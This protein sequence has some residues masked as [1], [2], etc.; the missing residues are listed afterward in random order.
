ME[1]VRVSTKDSKLQKIVSRLHQRRSSR[2][3]VSKSTKSKILTPAYEVR[4]DTRLLKVGTSSVEIIR[5]EHGSGWVPVRRVCEIL[6][7]APNSQ[8]SKL[9][10]SA[11]ATLEMIYSSSRD[12]KS[13]EHFCISIESVSVWVSTIDQG[14]IKGHKT[15]AY[16]IRSCR[17]GL[18]K[19]GTSSDPM[20]RLRSIAG[21][22]PDRFELLA[23][24]GDES[25]LHKCL[26]KSKVHGEWFSPCSGILKEIR[27]LGFDPNKPIAV[28]GMKGI[29]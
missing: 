19:I 2:K 18:I 11:W 24:G 13:Y 16:F 25:R 12:G 5:D 9:K 20:K 7:V 22:Y 4:E 17:T 27:E 15:E 3:V 23:I 21:H 28:A 6:G 1:E 29:E 14:R 10:K 26:S 8:C